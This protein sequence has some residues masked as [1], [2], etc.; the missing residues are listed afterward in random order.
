MKI[1][2]F[3]VICAALAALLSSCAQDKGIIRIPTPARPAGQQ[4]M[5][6]F[7]AEPIENVGVGIVGVGDRGSGA[8][9]RLTYVPG[10]HVAAVCDIE[11]DRVQKNIDLLA[12]RGQQATPYSG[13]E[14]AYKQLC[15]DPSVDLVYICTDWLHH[16]PIA[17]YAMEHG[18][19]V[20]IEVPS[21]ETLQA[22]WD[23]VNTSERTRQHCIILENCC[24]DFFELT[25]LA[26][27]QAGVFGEVIHAEG[28]YNH[29]LDPFWD[30]YWHNWRLDFNQTH[31]GDLYPTHGFGPVCQALNIHRGDRLT[32]LVS[33]DTDP[34]NGPKLVEKRT[35]KPCT[36]FQNGDVTMTM[37]RTAKGKSILIEHDVMTP[38]PYDRMYQLVGTDGYAG[39]YPVEEI[40]LR[41]EMPEEVNYQDLD[42]EKVYTG[43][44]LEELMAKYPNPILTPELKAMAEEVG[45][46]G[47]MDFIMDYRLM[48]CLNH[49][50]PLDMDVYDLAEWCCVTELSRISL[51]NGC[52]PVEVPDFTRGA[53]DRVDGFSYAFAE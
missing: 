40:C 25:A 24:Y 37:L 3:F 33:M 43:A 49:G 48:Y 8:V 7:R 35:G 19:H 23:L 11:P 6:Q 50:L 1:T 30:G 53:W 10:C 34:F 41:A 38:R 44:E 36:D 4:D 51:Q 5:I 42:F 2:R 46:H 27:A 52:R 45:G 22:C 31:R 18:K 20:A 47:G 39:K 15:E 12:S 16:V 17:L 14:D 29:N 28:A 26:M 9:D 13:S 21:A 32:T